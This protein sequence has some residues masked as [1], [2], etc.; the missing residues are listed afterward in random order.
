MNTGQEVE[1][2]YFNGETWETVSTWANDRLAWISL[3]NDFYGYRTINIYG[4]IIT[5]KSL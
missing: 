4:K 5:D 2:Q 1:L 3:G